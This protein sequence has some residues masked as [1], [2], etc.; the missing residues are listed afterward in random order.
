[1]TGVA[2]SV[3]QSSVPSRA[4][5]TVKHARLVELLDRRGAESLVL[6]TH[7]ALGWALDGAR[8]HVSLAGDPVVA[9][10]EQLDEARVLDRSIRARRNRR[11]HHGCRDAR[12]ASGAVLSRASSRG[13]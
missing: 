6:R 7:T 12:H 11:R 8:T 3:A 1:M 2:A 9:T 13:R 10:V 5:R 4:E